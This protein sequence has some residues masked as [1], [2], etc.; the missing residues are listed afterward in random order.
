MKK[1]LRIFTYVLGGVAVAIA[2]IALA[3]S[4]LAERRLGRSVEVA[5][6][7]LPYASGDE[8]LR[9]GK[10]LL[11]DTDTLAL[12]AFLRTL[13]ARPHGQR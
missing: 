12:H 13:P 7:P 10:Y 9:R 6:A 8:A 5:A 4:Q 1:T 11:D 2:A 3:G